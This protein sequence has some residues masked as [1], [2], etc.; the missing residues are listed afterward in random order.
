MLFRLRVHCTV[1]SISLL[2]GEGVLN[3]LSSLMSQLLE[4][5]LALETNSSAT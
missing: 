4:I 5:W 2:Q 1:P 3:S